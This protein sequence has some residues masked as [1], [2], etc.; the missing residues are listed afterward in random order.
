MNRILDKQRR[1]LKRRVHIRKRILGTAERPRMSV[2]RS[3]RHL[4]VQ[5]IDDSTGRTLVSAADLEK[6]LRE[7][8][9][10]VA[11]AEK[12]G[13]TLGARLKEKNIAQVVFDRNGYLYHGIVK[14]VAEGARK[15]GIRL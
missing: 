11:N 14:A 13:E 15:A 9:P 12:L 2:F 5:V 10:S 4:Y 3:N 6:S 1:R 8:K 7:L